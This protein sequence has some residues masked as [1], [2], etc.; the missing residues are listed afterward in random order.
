[1]HLRFRVSSQVLLIIVVAFPVFK[2]MVEQSTWMWDVYRSR[3]DVFVD[4]WKKR[5]VSV[6][7]V[8]HSLSMVTCIC[9]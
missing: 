4:E 1:V 5:M 8:G 7:N 3:A 9:I 6:L 2:D